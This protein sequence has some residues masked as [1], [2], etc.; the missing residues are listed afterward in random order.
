MIELAEMREG[1]WRVLLCLL[2]TTTTRNAKKI[3]RK[4][5]R[6][7]YI[8]TLDHCQTLKAVRVETIRVIGQAGCYR[9]ALFSQLTLRYVH[10]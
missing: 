3:K 2:L 1:E 8:N 7:R 4:E 10:T 9:A 6:E 5:I